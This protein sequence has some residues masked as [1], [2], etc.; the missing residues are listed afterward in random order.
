[1]FKVLFGIWFNVI[2]HY[3]I[4]QIGAQSNQVLY[5]NEISIKNSAQ[6]V[7]CLV[8]IRNAVKLQENDSSARFVPQIW[9]SRSDLSGVSMKQLAAFCLKVLQLNAPYFRS[10]TA[11]A[12]Y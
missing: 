1:M 5:H 12:L 10:G 4:I 2:C 3:Q 7:Q 9:L 6:R 8:I 11:I